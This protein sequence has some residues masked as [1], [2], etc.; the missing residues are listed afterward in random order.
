MKEIITPVLIF[1]FIVIAT[2]IS[3]VSTTDIAKAYF[4]SYAGN[5]IDPGTKSKPFK[6]LQKLNTLKLY[7]GTRIYLKGGEEFSGTLALNL[8]G[9]PENPIVIS[10][11]ENE[12]GNAV[13][14]G[15]DKEAVILQGNYFELKNINVKGSVRENGNVT[16]GISLGESSYGLIENI[17]AEG[18]Q[19][20]GLEVKSCNNIEVKDVYALDNGFCGIHITGSKEKDQQIFL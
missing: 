1:A 9:L 15:G 14:G 8:N 4:V 19:K 17:R 10:S 18:F 2:N 20:S 13:I 3:C 11:Y 5:D 7:P 12:N 16:N 6:S